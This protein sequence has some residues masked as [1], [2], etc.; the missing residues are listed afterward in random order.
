MNQ[1]IAIFPGSFDPFTIGHHSIVE[2]ALPL[3]DKIVV[4]VGMNSKKHSFLPEIDRLDAIRRLYADEPRMEVIAYSGLTVEAAEQCGARYILRGVRTVKDFEYEKTLADINRKIAG[5][6]TVLLYTL[7][8][9]GS[10]SSS[11]VR[12]LI[13][14]GRDVTDLLPPGYTFEI[15][16]RRCDMRRGDFWHIRAILA[17]Q[18]RFAATTETAYGGKHRKQSLC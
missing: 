5:L 9:Y 8:E 11:I 14:L 10:I 18:L 4:A 17:Q 6:E 7:P 1:R 3:F 12:E 16:S 15:F 2:R 13:S